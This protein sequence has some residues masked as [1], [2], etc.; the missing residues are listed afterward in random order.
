MDGGRGGKKRKPPRRRK[1]S[2]TYLVT[3]GPRALFSADRVSEPTRGRECGHT[4]DICIHELQYR[5][6]TAITTILLL[7]YYYWRRVRAV[8]CTQKCDNYDCGAVDTSGVRRRSRCKTVLNGLTDLYSSTT[9]LQWQVQNVQYFY[10]VF[11]SFHQQY[12]NCLLR[13]TITALVRAVTRRSLRYTLGDC[14]HYIFLSRNE[15]S[16][17]TAL[18]PVDVL[19]KY[20]PYYTGSN[21]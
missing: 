1:R 20:N 21:T 16:Q 7:L 12:C 15:K 10:L 6:T 4:H 9:N 18:L 17:K 5:R 11:V 3:T 13:L 8:V 14:C 2:Y 19:R